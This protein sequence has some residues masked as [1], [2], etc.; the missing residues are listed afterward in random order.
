VPDGFVKWYDPNRDEGVVEHNG[1]EY[2][3]RGRDIDNKAKQAGAPVHFDISHTDPGDVATNVEHRAGTRTSHTT[4][5][6]GDLTGAHHPSDKGQDEEVSHNE[7]TYDRRAYG[8]QPRKLAEDWI[9]SLS[10]GAVD[11]AAELYA[12][13]AT[14]HQGDRE[15]SGGQRIHAWLQRSALNGTPAS[16]AELTGDGADRYVIRWHTLPGEDAAMEI[17]LRITDGRITEQWVAEA[18]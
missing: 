4:T 7:R 3:V 2:A 6:V 17:T 11:R 16:E 9:G 1:R 10:S 12:P 8:D 18:A 5:G 13:D 15:L 14:I